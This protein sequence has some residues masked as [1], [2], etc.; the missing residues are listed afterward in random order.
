MLGGMLAAAQ[1][2]MDA[3]DDSVKSLSFSGDGRFVATG[4]LS[5]EVRIWHVAE[6]LQKA[7]IS[8]IPSFVRK[9][10]E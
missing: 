2:V 9:L 6:I 7:Q 3:S 10:S 1:P 5:E 4:T 8:N